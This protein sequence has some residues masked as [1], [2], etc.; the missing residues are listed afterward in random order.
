MQAQTVKLSSIPEPMLRFIDNRCLDREDNICAF[1]N[2]AEIKSVHFFK[3]K[4]R[5]NTGTGQY[6][7][8]DA[9]IEIW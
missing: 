6:R 9:D 5:I 1:Y 3:G 8:N 4:Y 2:G 7:V